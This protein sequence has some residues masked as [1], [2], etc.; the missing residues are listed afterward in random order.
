MQPFTGGATDIF[1]WP[2]GGAI[3]EAAKLSEVQRA[4]LTHCVREL[5]IVSGRLPDHLRVDLMPALRD[6]MVRGLVRKTGHRWEV[7][8]RGLVIHEALA[9]AEQRRPGQRN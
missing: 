9:A 6:L 4:L 7:T 5:R 1:G 3:A 8:G 2:V